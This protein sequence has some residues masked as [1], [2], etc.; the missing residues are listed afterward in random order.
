MSCTIR[1]RPGYIQCNFKVYQKLCI[2]H[3]HCFLRILQVRNFIQV[4][5]CRTVTIAMR[6]LAR[7]DVP[8]FRL[9]SVSRPI[10]FTSI[11][12]DFIDDQKS[13]KIINREGF[14]WI[15]TMSFISALYEK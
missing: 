12:F 6:T 10:Y 9:I 4:S 11:K 3:W 1:N 13:L 5:N 8:V 2:I 15:I 7:P 14:Y